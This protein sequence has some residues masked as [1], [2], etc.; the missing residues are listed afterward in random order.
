MDLAFFLANP[1]QRFEQ[2]L[3]FCQSRSHFFRHVNGR[4]QYKQI[5]LSSGFLA[6]L[7]SHMFG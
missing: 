3:T 2:N 6:M 5:L 4:S 7:R 1:A